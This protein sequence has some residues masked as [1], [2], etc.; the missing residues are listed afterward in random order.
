MNET[1]TTSDKYCLIIVICNIP[2]IPK[3]TAKL[4]PMDAESFSTVVSP[5]EKALTIV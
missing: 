1:I 5:K 2:R 3:R 4:S